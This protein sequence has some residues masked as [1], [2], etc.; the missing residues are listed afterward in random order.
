MNPAPGPIPLEYRVA[1]LADVPA[2]EALIPHSARTLQSTT[3]S[4][5]QLDGAIG[6]VFG[7]DTQLIRDGTYFVAVAGSRIVACGGWSRRKTAYGG[8][9]GK[10]GDDPLRDPATEPAMIRA[11]FV[12]PDFTRRGIGREF[13]R[14]SEAAIRAAGFRGIDIV[15]TLAGE[16]LYTACGYAVVERV[17]I[18]L[19]NGV[20]LPV[21]RMRKALAP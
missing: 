4:P 16:P 1:R 5:E 14:R 17:D 18:A 21:V 8:D 6:T 13:I 7:V 19:V 2:L 20:S 3:Y 12:H 10:S 15:A 9:K 11:F